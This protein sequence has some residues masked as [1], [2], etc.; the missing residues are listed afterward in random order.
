MTVGVRSTI[1]TVDRAVS[2]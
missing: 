2:S 1:A